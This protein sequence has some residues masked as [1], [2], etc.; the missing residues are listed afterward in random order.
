MEGANQ[1]RPSILGYVDLNRGIGVVL[2]IPYKQRPRADRGALERWVVQQH[3]R[4]IADVAKVALQLAPVDVGPDHL[5]Q[6]QRSF[7][8]REPAVAILVGVGHQNAEDSATKARFPTEG[9]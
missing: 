2:S 9:R 8:N 4:A 7:G 5:L 6:L 1:H 3:R